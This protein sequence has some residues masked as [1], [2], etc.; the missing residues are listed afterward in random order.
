VILERLRSTG[1]AVYVER[2]RPSLF[3]LRLDIVSGARRRWPRVLA[4]ATSGEYDAF[5]GRFLA[6]YRFGDTLVLCTGEA[7]IELDPN[8]RAN[9]SELGER[10]RL[11][12]VQGSRPVL[13]W[14]YE[15]PMS[16]LDRSDVHFEPARNDFPRAVYR[17]VS[18]PESWPDLYR[19]P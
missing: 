19:P 5:A 13:D 8:L 11:T 6:L 3:H 14:S 15:V 12:L 7:M 18:R 4:P 2:Y 1:R 16:A 9:F 10:N 17:M